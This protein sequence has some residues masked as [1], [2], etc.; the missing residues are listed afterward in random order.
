MAVRT[1]W[2][3][4]GRRYVFHTYRWYPDNTECESLDQRPD[5]ADEVRSRARPWRHAVPLSLQLLPRELSNSDNVCG[6]V[7]S[8]N[9]E[10]D[11]SSYKGSAIMSVHAGLSR[12]WSVAAL[13]CWGAGSENDKREDRLAED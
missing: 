12:V 6:R 8:A 1:S 13:S 2:R 5:D 11:P 3:M 10:S 9:I 7:C 4:T